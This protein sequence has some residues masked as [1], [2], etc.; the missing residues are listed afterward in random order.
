MNPLIN[1]QQQPNSRA[2]IDTS[3]VLQQAISM[4][5]QSSLNPGAMLQ[6]MLAAGRINQAQLTQAF[7]KAQDLLRLYGGNN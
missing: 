7:Q 6:Q 1:I 4:A 5:K 3:S 2:N